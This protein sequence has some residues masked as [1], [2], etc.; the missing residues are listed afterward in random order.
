MIP[1]YSKKRLAQSAYDNQFSITAKFSAKHS[2]LMIVTSNCI[3]SVSRVR[4]ALPRPDELPS[5][6]YLWSRFHYHMLHAIQGVNMRINDGS[7]P[8]LVLYRV[9]DV[10]SVEVRKLCCCIDI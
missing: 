1:A 10:L 8:R 5:L 6:A 9:V 2:F 3:S 7:P 4:G